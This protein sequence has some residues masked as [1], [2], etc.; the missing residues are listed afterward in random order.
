MRH[1]PV[2]H[3]GHHPSEYQSQPQRAPPSLEMP[4]QE[5]KNQELDAYH[6]RLTERDM[7]E[8]VGWCSVKYE[9]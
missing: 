8:V 9:K 2:A 5:A 1:Q 6:E 3:I 7:L 4:S